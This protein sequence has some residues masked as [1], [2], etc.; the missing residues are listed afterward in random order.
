[1]DLEI[2]LVQRQRLIICAN[3]H[4]KGFRLG[5]DNFILCSTGSYAG[6]TVKTNIINLLS[7]IGNQEYTATL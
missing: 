3:C 4:V 6:V 2:S 7:Q 5:R 1:M